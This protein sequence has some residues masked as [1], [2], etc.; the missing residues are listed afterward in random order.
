MVYKDFNDGLNLLYIELF[1]ENEEN[2]NIFQVIN[3]SPIKV[4][5]SL[6]KQL[7]VDADEEFVEN[8]SE[9]TID[10]FYYDFLD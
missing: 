4:K 8:N 9:E 2:E 7:R 5:E 1:I 10:D 6:I 3:F